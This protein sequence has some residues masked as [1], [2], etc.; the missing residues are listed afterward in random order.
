[1]GR[2]KKVEEATF[3][4]ALWALIRLV[5]AVGVL[6]LTV[7]I[8]IQAWFWVPVLWGIYDAAKD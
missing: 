8:G 7:S 6:V 2:R 1:M 4:E 5:W 3:W